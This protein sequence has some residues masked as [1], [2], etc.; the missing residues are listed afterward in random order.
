MQ[1]RKSERVEMITS[2][3]SSDAS[4]CD[5]SRTGVSCFHN[6]S[7]EKESFVVVKVNDLSLRA[8]V[9]YCQERK[10]DFRLGLQFWN[11]LP[12][13]QKKLNIL[14]EKYSKGIPVSCSVIDDVS[15]DKKTKR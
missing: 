6:K 2:T 11:I 14:V 12:E 13:I 5:L 4:L 7:K 1:E 15:K 8:K 10:T 3:G 9:A